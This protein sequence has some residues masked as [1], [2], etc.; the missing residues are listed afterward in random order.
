MQ[1]TW[2]MEEPWSTMLL[3]DS[4]PS[5]RPQSH[6]ETQTTY[7]YASPLCFVRSMIVPKTTHRCCHSVASAC[8][9]EASNRSAIGVDT[10]LRLP[11]DAR[12][13]RSLDDSTCSDVRGHRLL[14]G[15]ISKDNTGVASC[16][17]TRLHPFSIFFLG[18]ARRHSAGNLCPLLSLLQPPGIYRP[19]F[20]SRQPPRI[21][22]R[23]HVVGASLPRNLYSVFG[24]LAFAVQLPSPTHGGLVGFDTE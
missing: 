3:A 4:Y 10:R 15:S 21:S 2:M 11:C 6:H 9:R 22:A 24:T 12:P 23:S 13:R 5:Q 8:V 14:L 20:V 16:C 1:T 7:M 17:L 18:T 19:L